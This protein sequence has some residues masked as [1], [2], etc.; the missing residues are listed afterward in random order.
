MFVKRY[1][2]TMLGVLGKGVFHIIQLLF[3]IIRPRFHISEP[4]SRND[5]TWR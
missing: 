3:H 2:W 1:G 5:R 4:G